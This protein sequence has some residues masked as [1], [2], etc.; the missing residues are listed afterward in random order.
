[1]LPLSWKFN[2]EHIFTENSTYKPSS[3]ITKRGKRHH[4]LYKNPKVGEYQE[5]IISNLCSI[6][7]EVDIP[8]PENTFGFVNE[9]KFGIISQRYWNMDVTNCI[10]AVEDAYIRFF[11]KRKRDFDD[12][13]VLSNVGI[14]LPTENI[15]NISCTTYF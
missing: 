14:K 15:Y 9:W 12:S 4:F 3:M 11:H 8:L 7:G 1:M 10:K 6:L 2:I 13:Q 5:K